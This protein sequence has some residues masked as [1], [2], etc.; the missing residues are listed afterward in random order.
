MKPAPNCSSAISPDTVDWRSVLRRAQTGETAAFEELAAELGPRLRGL[1]VRLD[2]PMSEV[3]DLAIETLEKI[4]QK[5]D[6]VRNGD[7]LPWAFQVARNHLNDHFVRRP[8][9]V[10]PPEAADELAAPTSGPQPKA[11]A[12][13]RSVRAWIRPLPDADRHLLEG[14]GAGVPHGQLAQELGITHAAARKRAERL[15]KR[16]ETYLRADA[17][18]AA[19]LERRLGSLLLK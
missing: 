11:S 6:T 17:A 3:D 12:L 10:L 8:P 13:V 2:A 16:L 1:L 7:L 18:L 15:L 9:P 4:L 14:R 19:E 5:L